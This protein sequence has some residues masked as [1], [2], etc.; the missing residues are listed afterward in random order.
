MTTAGQL[1]RRGIRPW[2]RQISVSHAVP[3]TL[4]SWNLAQRGYDSPSRVQSLHRPL[5]ALGG[6]GR[7]WVKGGGASCFFFLA[8]CPGAALAALACVRSWQPEQTAVVG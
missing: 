5:Q 7:R 3:L 4:L 1:Q 8:R 6:V 2:Q